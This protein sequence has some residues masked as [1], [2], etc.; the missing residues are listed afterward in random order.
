MSK[1]YLIRHGESQANVD[2]RLHL[3]LPDHEIAL[4]SRG[5][6]QAKEAA[7][8]L[9]NKF[10]S[11]YGYSWAHMTLWNSPYRRTRD[12][13]KIIYDT[14]YEQGHDLINY[15]AHVHC[16]ENIFLC[17][18]QFGLFDGLEDNEI[19]AK[20]PAEYK[21]WNLCKRFNGKFWARYPM[22]ESPFDAAIRI[23]QSFDT[24]K[25]G[26]NII[27]AHGAVIKLFLMMWFG[28]PPEWFNEE[29]TI[30]NCGIHLIEYDRPSGCSE[31]KIIF[32]GFKDGQLIC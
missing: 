24:F 32:N 31:E 2:K 11:V 17:E 8:Q 6:D 20:F 9:R 1:I 23:S 30:G 5:I 22:G 27:V 25:Q 26:N 16:K 29:K 4:S 14:L 15:H 18:Q 7:R 12:T 19:E 21:T 13:A 10:T 3:N 28:R